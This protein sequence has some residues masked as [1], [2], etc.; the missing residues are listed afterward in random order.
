MGRKFESAISAQATTTNVAVVYL[1]S[2]RYAKIAT[3]TL[4]AGN[5][6]D[7][8]TVVVVMG[9]RAHDHHSVSR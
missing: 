8:L 4:S 1:T 5:A 3:A 2:S 7:W 9:F 6:L